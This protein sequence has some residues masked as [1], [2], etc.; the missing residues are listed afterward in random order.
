MANSAWMDGEHAVER[1]C[2][3]VD[4]QSINT[5]TKFSTKKNASER[6]NWFAAR[7]TINDGSGGEILHC[8]APWCA[9]IRGGT[10]LAIRASAG[11]ATANWAPHTRDEADQLVPRDGPQTVPY[12]GTR[13]ASPL[14]S[15]PMPLPTR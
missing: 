13:A 4:V 8:G 7:P 11:C 14:S 1:G 5:D 6:H 15:L 10:H 2:K 3:P 12:D 9:S